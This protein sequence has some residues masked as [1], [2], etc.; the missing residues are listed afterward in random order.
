VVPERLAALHR[1]RPEERD[2]DLA[3]AVVGVRPLAVA[4][5]A[6]FGELLQRLVALL[7]YFAA[8]LRRRVFEDG[9]GR[10]DELPITLVLFRI[11][12]TASTVA[13]ET[14]YDED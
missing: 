11:F 12:G 1:D 13:K 14:E 7:R 8:S 5:L 6:D 3:P 4:E 2:R 9:D 10:V